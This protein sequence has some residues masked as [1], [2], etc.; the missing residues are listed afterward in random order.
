MRYLYEYSSC[1]SFDPSKL[2][3]INSS[4]LTQNS[5]SERKCKLFENLSDF[6]MN[7]FP[8]YCYATLGLF[9]DS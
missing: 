4:D 6:R 2:V 5:I 3:L 1:S 8:I 7:T 9:P